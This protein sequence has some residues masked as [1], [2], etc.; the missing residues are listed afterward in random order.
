M[1]SLIGQ[2]RPSHEDQIHFHHQ[3]ATGFP[4]TTSPK[5][6]TPFPN[7]LSFDDKVKI[8]SKSTTM[9]TATSPLC[10]LNITF[11]V[12]RSSVDRESSPPS[13]IRKFAI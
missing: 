6:A 9:S 12:F 1:P 4:T 13:S 5:S 11:L 3:Q 2:H 10:S 7:S 8:R